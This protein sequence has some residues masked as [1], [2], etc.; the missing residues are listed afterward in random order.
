L[1][2]T[3]PPALRAHAIR[4]VGGTSHYLKLVAVSSAST[5]VA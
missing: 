1:T 2:S 4:I 3:F 5:D